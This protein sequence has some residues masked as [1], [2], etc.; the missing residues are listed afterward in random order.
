MEAH[1]RISAK[2]EYL[3]EAEWQVDSKKSTA[4]RQ[5]DEEAA[6]A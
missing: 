2:D 1:E 6:V 5:H 4:G 3:G